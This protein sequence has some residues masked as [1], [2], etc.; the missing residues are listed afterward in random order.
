VPDPAV[1]IDPDCTVS[2]GRLADIERAGVSAW[3]A[4]ATERLGGWLWRYSA[5]GSQRANAIACL[6]P[7]DRDVEAA[8][9]RVEALYARAGA[10]PQFQVTAVSVPD[11][12]DRRLAA[13]GYRVNDPCWI[14][15]KAIGPGGGMPAD[16]CVLGE[17]VAD[18]LD[19]YTSAI[20]PDRRRTA[21]RI[22]AGVPGPR[23]F[24]LAGIGGRPVATALCVI[25]GE[26][27]IA[28]CVATRAEARRQGAGARVMRAAETWAAAQGARI[29]ALGMT[30]ANIAGR[31]LYEGLGMRRLAPYHMRIRDRTARG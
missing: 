11:D 29:L 21:P 6:D 20:T 30:Q 15:A 8:I 17:P 23:A 13:R 19:V 3:P 28:E 27:A 31:A 26:V 10:P 5:G 14:L 4:L 22:L 2:L 18:W 12:L 7:P 25:A 16:V 9:D 1:P 24:L